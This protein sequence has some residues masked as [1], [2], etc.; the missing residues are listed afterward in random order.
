MR[1]KCSRYMFIAPILLTHIKVRF[2]KKSLSLMHGISC[3]SFREK[4]GM[5]I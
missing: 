4:E 3:P 1:I 5:K 2:V